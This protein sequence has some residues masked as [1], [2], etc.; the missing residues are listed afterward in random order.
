M[1]GNCAALAEVPSVAVESAPAAAP[2]FDETNRSRSG[3]AA[4]SLTHSESYQPLLLML[5]PFGLGIC[6]DRYLLNGFSNSFA[7]EWSVSLLAV[8]VWLPLWKATRNWLAMI[9]LCMAI[10]MAAGAWHDWQR[11]YFRAD[12]IGRYATEAPQPICCEA[13]AVAAPEQVPTPPLNPLRSAPVAPQFRLLVDVVALRN[14]EQWQP[15]SGRA[16]LTVGSNQLKIRAGDRMRIFG[17]LAA[18]SPAA[19]PGDF[20]YAEFAR[21][22]WQLSLLR[23]KSGEGIQIIA[24]ASAWHPTRWLDTLRQ[25]G[26]QLLDRFI[27]HDHFG[28][29]SAILLGQREFVD[30]D[31]NEAFLE[32]GTIHIL[33]IAGLHIGIVATL[34][35]AILGAGWLPRRVAIVCVMGIL[36]AYMMLTMARPPMMRATL[37]VW[38]VCGGMLLGRRSWGWNSLA[39]AAL[40]VL[41][42]NP[43]SLT[44]AGVQLSFLSVAAIMWMAP[45]LLASAKTDPL[46]RLIATTRPWPQRTLAAA[47][48]HLFEM[49][50]IGLAIW[51]IITPLTMSR[52]HILSPS[53]LILNLLL[54]PVLAVVVAAGMGVLAFGWWLPPLAAAFGWLCDRNLAVLENTVKWVATLPGARFWVPGPSEI[55]LAV[56]YLAI[57]A[58]MFLPRRLPPLRWRVALLGGWCG[59][60]LLGTA[61]LH[62]PGSTLRCTFIAVG[63]G[64]AAFWNYPMVARCFTMPADWALRPA[65]RSRSVI[66]SGRGA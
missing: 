56:F 65:G 2:H 32:T 21:D 27:P 36:G 51:A 7:V 40:V 53:G 23:V 35:F 46:D 29:A 31:T 11:N 19:N 48:R 61:P 39:L 41:A 54:I 6:I 17:S 33:C 66:I 9:S 47:R 25:A 49:F 45:K 43:A 59:V 13:I 22:E 16:R 57:A 18:P 1:D 30:E 20:D 5:I 58:A 8:V 34:L 12:D 37:L 14:A 60:G 24:A 52:F 10:G 26:M 4:A 44:H 62:P 42:V 15:A 64:G 28:L 38:I 3:P 63:H 55:W 50:V